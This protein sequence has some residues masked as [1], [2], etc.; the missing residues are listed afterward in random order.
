MSNLG[1]NDSSDR[2]EHALLKVSVPVQIQTDTSRSPIRGTTA[3]LS[4]ERLLHRGNFLL[5]NRD[6]FGLAPL[7]RNHRID[8]RHGR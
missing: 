8:C 4:L 2:R 6:Q 5:P 1:N 3:D 7:R